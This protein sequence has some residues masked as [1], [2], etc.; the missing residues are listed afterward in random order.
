MLIWVCLGLGLKVLGPD[1]ELTREP[2]LPPSTE[3]IMNPEDINQ[4]RSVVQGAVERA[5]NTFYTLDSVRH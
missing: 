5:P 1:F 3:C 2:D 4:W